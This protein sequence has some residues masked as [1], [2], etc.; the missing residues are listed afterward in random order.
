MNSGVILG[1]GWAQRNTVVISL[2]RRPAAKGPGVSGLCH[3]DDSGC[4]VFAIQHDLYWIFLQ[5]IDE[6]FIAIALW[7]TGHWEILAVSRC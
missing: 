7:L 3:R 2:A 5:A 4:E 6:Y 1:A